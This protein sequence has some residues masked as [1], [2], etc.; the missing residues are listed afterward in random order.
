MARE[1]SQI[2]PPS[3]LRVNRK[4]GV[5]VHVQLQTQ[6]RHLIDTGSLKPGMQLP[7]VR[8]L[9][10]FLPAGFGGHREFVAQAVDIRSEVHDDIVA[11]QWCHM[12]A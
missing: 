12:Q 2:V 6:V 8:Q 3:G 5:P 9:A 10:G 4:S 7:T 11:P 1:S